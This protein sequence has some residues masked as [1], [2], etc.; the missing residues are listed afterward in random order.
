M[1]TKFS[2]F[3]RLASSS[4][5]RDKIRL[6]RRLRE[7]PVFGSIWRAWCAW[8]ARMTQRSSE[9]YVAM[10]KRTFEL[11]ASADIVTPGSMDGDY[12]AGSWKQ[13]NEWPDYELFLMKYVPEHSELLA[14]EYGCGPGR[15][16]VRWSSRFRRIDGVDISG[17]N[18]ENARTF[19]SGQLAADKTPSLY[20]TEGMDCGEAPEEYYDFAFSTICLQHICVYDVRFAILKS[21]YGCLKPGGRVSVQ[22]GFGSPSPGTVPYEANYYAAVSTNRECDVA[23]SSASQVEADLAKIGF[24]DFESWVRPVGPGDCHPNWIFFT[25][26]KPAKR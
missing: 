19:V 5:A 10:Q 1:L 21:L 3:I 12:V 17:R 25:A 9:D 16:L 4:D 22:M 6:D 13:H 26:I 18:L 2:N 11:L 7:V 23:V 14:I 20:L 8:K 24:S 15:N